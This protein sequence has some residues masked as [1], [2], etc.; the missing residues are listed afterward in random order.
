MLILAKNDVDGLVEQ[1]RRP[2]YQDLAEIN[3]ELRQYLYTKDGRVCFRYSDP[4]AQYELT[5]TMFEAYFGLHVKLERC[6]LCPRLGNRLDY[7]VWASRLV[8]QTEP[9]AAE[10]NSEEPSSKRRK[11]ADDDGVVVCIDIGVGASAVYPLI[12]CSLYDN[13]K[14]V[15]LDVSAPS[16]KYA[17]TQVKANNLETRIQLVK[18]EPS[19]GKLIPQS[20]LESKVTLTMC[21][22]PFYESPEDLER[23]ASLKSEPPHSQELIAS[24][25]ELYTPGGEKAFT[26]RLL[27]QSLEDKSKVQWYTT[28]LGKKET[29]CALVQKLRE[30]NITNYAIHEI[31]HEATRRWVLGW[32]FDLWHSR[33]GTCRA[34]SQSLKS[35]NP[36]PREL[37]VRQTCGQ[38]TA[39]AAIKERL[40]TSQDIRVDETRDHDG[41][42]VYCSGDVWGRG[43]RRRRVTTI[44]DEAV[45]QVD[46]NE[47][48]TI[49]WW[50]YGQDPKLFDSFCGYVKSTVDSVNTSA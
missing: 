11:L 30:N 32:S 48:H 44:K 38:N 16:L 20:A 18:T 5:E 4:V 17:E 10:K 43:Y 9:I 27:D 40:T 46:V 22:P 19:D 34:T 39:L 14:F 33:D 21:N 36:E 31:V 47:D 6:H 45:F 12:G 26:Q 15:G 7:I 37:K 2:R 3:H 42:V 24:D 50:R 23:S 13:W 29:L 49:V 8:G 28:M 35:Y 25:N 41:F 1:V